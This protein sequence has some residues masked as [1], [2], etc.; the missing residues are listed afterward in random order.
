MKKRYPKWSE[1]NQLDEWNRLYRQHMN[2]FY[3]FMYDA[4]DEEL[5]PDK[6]VNHKNSAKYFKQLIEEYDNWLI[7]GDNHDYS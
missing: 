4:P 2:K 7:T 1:L 3:Y 5:C 6:A